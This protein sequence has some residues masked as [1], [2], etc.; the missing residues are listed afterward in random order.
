[1]YYKIR[2]LKSNEEINKFTKKW[3]RS[4]TYKNPSSQ[5]NL[6]EVQKPSS[7][8]AENVFNI[9]GSMASSNYNPNDHAIFT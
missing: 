7:G 3:Y 2:L 4:E 5:R 1:M 6:P 9:L 8:K